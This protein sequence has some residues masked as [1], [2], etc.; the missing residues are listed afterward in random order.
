MENFWIKSIKELLEILLSE[1]IERNFK[2]ICSDGKYHSTGMCSIAEDLFNEYIISKEEYQ[3][4]KE[5]LARNKPDDAADAHWYP[6]TPSGNAKRIKFL[7]FKIKN[8]IDVEVEYKMTNKKKIFLQQ[9]PNDNIEWAAQQIIN[10]FTNSQFMLLQAC[11]EKMDETFKKSWGKDMSF[12]DL[13]QAVDIVA[14]L[15]NVQS[16]ER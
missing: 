7:E 15:S 11:F 4:I 3:K 10:H 16:Y 13:K 14:E 9:I 5:F 6:S 8:P 1:C 2:S 12:T